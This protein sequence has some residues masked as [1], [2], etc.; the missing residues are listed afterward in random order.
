MVNP[1]PFICAAMAGQRI[2]Q[3]HLEKL[4]GAGGFGAVFLINER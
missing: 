3:Y 1:N 2:G 4:L